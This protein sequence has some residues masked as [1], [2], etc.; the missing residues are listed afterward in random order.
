MSFS[1]L[2]PLGQPPPDDVDAAARLWLEYK[3]RGIT[4]DA[5]AVFWQSLS[6]PD[7]VEARANELAAAPAA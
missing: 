1:E 4:K 6:D 7:A 5:A 3:Q 2:L